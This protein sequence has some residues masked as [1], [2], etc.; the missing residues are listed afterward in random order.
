MDSQTDFLAQITTSIESGRFI[1]ITLSNSRVKHEELLNTYIRLIDIKRRPH[2]SFTYH[3]RTNDQV[4][5]HDIPAGLAEIGRLMD[6]TFKNAMLFTSDADF[7]LQLSKKGKASLKEL[8]PSHPVPTANA[9]SH[10]N[11][12]KKQL[13]GSEKY[14]RLLGVA[15]TDGQII[16]RMADKY[17]Q[18]NKYLEV[19]EDLID[20]LHWE[21]PIHIVDMGSGKG[22]LTFALYD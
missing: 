22:Y 6:D 1:K 10:D 7:L 20:P 18:I 8:K 9:R 14:L 11:P 16:P 4:K 13:A 5:N 17:R 2:L 19:M 21:R 12:R 15:D 3:Y